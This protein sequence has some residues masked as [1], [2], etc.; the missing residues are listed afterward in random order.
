MIDYKSN[1]YDL[2]SPQEWTPQIKTFLNETRNQL[3]GSE[4]RLFMARVVFN[5]GYGGSLR[6]ERELGWD[7]TTIRKGLAELKS[8]I[9]C[10][11]NYSGKGRKPIEKHLVNLLEDIENIV[12]PISQTDPS[13]RTTKLYSPITAAEVHRR[14]KADKGYTDEE[15]PTIRTI[16]SKLNQMGYRLKKVGKSKPKKKS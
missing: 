12:S 4:R 11:D 14:L 5:L 13:F 1:D 15:L 8:G 2:F 7:R 16:N 10:C 9:T 6:A 3:K